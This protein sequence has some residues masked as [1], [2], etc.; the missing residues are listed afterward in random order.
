LQDD[1]VTLYMDVVGKGTL[2]PY[3]FVR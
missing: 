1:G 2:K 3:T